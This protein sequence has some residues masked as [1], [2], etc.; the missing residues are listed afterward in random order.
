MCIR[1]RLCAVFVP[2]AFMG[3]LTGRLYKQ[4][5][6]TIA[7]SVII[8]GIVALTLTPA[9][10]AVLLKPHQ[11]GHKKWAP[12]EWFN[13]AFDTVTGGYGR[14]VNAGLGASKTML[15]AFV[16]M[17]VLAGW[18][19]QRTPTAF[20]PS[21]A[22]GYF[23]AFVA[24]PDAASLQRTDAVV[25]RVEQALMADPAVENVTVLEGLDFISNANQTNAATIFV[26]LKPWHDR[27]ADSLQLTA[28]VARAN[29]SIGAISEAQGFAFNMP[30][31]PGLGVTA[32][33][34]MYIQNR[35]VG[36]YAQ[37]VAVGQ[38]FLQELNK[39]CLLYTS[40]AADERS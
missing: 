16:V 3:G 4:F 24:L 5:A 36:D 9:L 18:L 2:V 7:V 14:I 26:T 11:P 19:F 15:A 32:G 39:T 10:C 23:V 30:E 40:D 35:G 29:A 20:L 13:R 33:L 21:E 27:E 6:L 31:I 22:K 28:V 25:Q 1:D 12:F 8:S 34:E 37:F 38:E 17:L